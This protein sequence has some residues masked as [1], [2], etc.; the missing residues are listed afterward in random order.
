MIMLIVLCERPL[1]LSNRLTR[2]Q[3]SLLVVFLTG[4]DALERVV[5]VVVL[6]LLG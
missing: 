1:V 6:A 4:V 3:L 5:G 2:Q